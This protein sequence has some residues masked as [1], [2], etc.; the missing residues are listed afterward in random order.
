MIFYRP[1]QRDE[2]LVREVLA[3]EQSLKA[4]QLFLERARDVAEWT[5]ENIYLVLK[6]IMDE[7]GIKMPVVAVPIRVLVFGEKISPVFDKT[8][9]L[10]GKET[11]LANIES[12][13]A[14]L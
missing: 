4:V 3:N 2:A 11:V 1:L 14:M 13:L 6:G 12:G 10:F 8:L 5:P 7:M 9:A